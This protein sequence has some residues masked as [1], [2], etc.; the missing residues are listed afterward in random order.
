MIETIALSMIGF[1]TTCSCSH[2]LKLTC[3]FCVTT[4]WF[5]SLKW[6]PDSLVF[7]INDPPLCSLTDWL[8][9]CFQVKFTFE[10]LQPIN[11]FVILP[12]NQSINQSINALHF[13]VIWN[14]CCSWDPTLCL[15]PSWFFGCGQLYLKCINHYLFHVFGGSFFH[16]LIDC[17]MGQCTDKHLSASTHK[18]LHTEA[19]GAGVCVLGLVGVD[20][21][22]GLGRWQMASKHTAA[23][24]NDSLRNTQNNIVQLQCRVLIVLLILCALE[25][26]CFVFNISFRLKIRLIVSFRV[27]M[28]RSE[29]VSDWIN[30]VLG[31]NEKQISA[32]ANFFNG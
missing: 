11:P 10:Q 13:S 19:Y 28:D 23:C 26:E 25:R 31:C 20:W 15:I 18:R 27:M 6:K 24:M 21:T 5:P 3:G 4:K 7:Q 22:Y 1:C 8:L 32:D 29:S 12:V 9:G 14:H 16:L 30:H 2:I 17:F